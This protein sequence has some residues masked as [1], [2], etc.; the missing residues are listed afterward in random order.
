[1][2]NF[3]LLRKTVDNSQVVQKL[4]TGLST[5]FQA[6]KSGPENF[7]QGWIFSKKTVF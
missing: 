3:G 6:G 7:F 5:C 4:S 1:M 2:N